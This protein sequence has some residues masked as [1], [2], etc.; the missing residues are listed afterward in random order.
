MPTLSSL[1]L[2]PIKSCGGL[3]LREATLT[4]IGLMSGA[5]CDRE[6]MVIDAK[7]VCL[8]QREHPR[9]ALITP[10]LTATTLEVRAPGM[11]LLAIPL[12]QPDSDTRTV[13]TKIWDDS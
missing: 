2:Y 12:A 9:M 5:I 11:P 8:T 3:S 6:W 4:T 7:G 10:T 13:S 1:T